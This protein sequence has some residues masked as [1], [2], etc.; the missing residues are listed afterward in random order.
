VSHRTPLPLLVGALLALVLAV[1]AL[2]HAELVSS[3]PADR[4]VLDRSPGAI[5]LI[6]NDRLISGRS[7]F[8]LVGPGGDTGLR[9][10]G[11]VDA[12]RP[13][14]LV[15]VIADGAPAPTLAPGTWEVRWRAIADDG[16]D[17]LQRGI[18]RFT[19]LPPTPSPQTPPP[20]TAT[21]GGTNE[22]ATHA[23]PTPSPAATPPTAA[24]TA[25]PGEPAAST[26]DVLLPI[27]LGL[28]LVGG[29]G[30]LVIRRSRRA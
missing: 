30:V 26:G 16:H 5:T 3:D 15:L 27:V 11:E 23:P 12:E 6:F 19:V 8:E 14:R 10:R 28:V 24:P 7:Y 22:P 25:V 4:A 18:V 21:P 9:L 13:R 20:P 2:A 29:V 17:E 1:P